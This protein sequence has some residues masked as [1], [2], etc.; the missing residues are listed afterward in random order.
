MLESRALTE[1]AGAYASRHYAGNDAGPQKARGQ[2]GQREQW[3]DDLAEWSDWRKTG[4]HIKGS[5][6]GPPTLVIRV[7]QL[8]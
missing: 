2:D 1:L 6:I 4:R 7:R 3:T 5:F 8:D